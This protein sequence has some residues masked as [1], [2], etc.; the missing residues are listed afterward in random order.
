MGQAV[1]GGCGQGLRVHVCPRFYVEQ[2]HVQVSHA[3]PLGEGDRVLVKDPIPYFLKHPGSA[4][5]A[6]HQLKLVTG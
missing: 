6:A 4:G 3:P 5:E 1:G 2:L